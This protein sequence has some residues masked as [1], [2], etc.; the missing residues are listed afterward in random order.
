MRDILAIK[1][2]NIHASEIFIRPWC[3]SVLSCLNFCWIAMCCALYDN[4]SCLAKQ[5]VFFFFFF[6]I[7]RVR[8]SW[9]EITRSL[10]VAELADRTLRLFVQASLLYDV[11]TV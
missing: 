8:A 5:N 7:L 1:G 2:S 4:I 9:T 10:A 6:L 3:W 11:R